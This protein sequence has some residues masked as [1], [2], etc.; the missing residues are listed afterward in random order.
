MMKTVTIVCAGLFLVTGCGG[1]QNTPSPS[2]TPSRGTQSASTVPS[3]G[4]PADPKDKITLDPEPIYVKTVKYNLVDEP[5]ISE[6]DFPKLEKL[7]K[8]IG[9][10]L[11]ALQIA[12]TGM[13]AAGNASTQDTNIFFSR[14]MPA[15]K[16]PDI[17]IHECAHIFQKEVLGDDWSSL[18][19]IYPP[20]YVP[21]TPLPVTKDYT[22]KKEKK[23]Y[24]IWIHGA[25]FNADCIAKE[26]GSKTFYY[27]TDC[28]GK[29]AE[30]AKDIINRKIPTIP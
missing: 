2:Q 16:A 17:L 15:S 7:A 29:R 1:P 4:I 8:D 26:L 30:A 12:D 9:C 10:E 6:K 21:M 25:E 13:V 24:K 18:D 3:Q 5:P 27:T 23:L 19:K 28:S 20:A 11:G 22:T 14:Y